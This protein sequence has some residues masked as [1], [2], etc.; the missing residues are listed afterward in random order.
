[1]AVYAEVVRKSPPSKITGSLPYNVVVSGYVRR[2]DTKQPLANARVDINFNGRTATVYT[3]SSGYFS[4]TFTVYEYGA[5]FVDIKATPKESDVK[6]SGLYFTFSIWDPQPLPAGNYYWVA[7]RMLV[8]GK[9][10]EDYAPVYPGDEVVVEGYLYK[11]GSPVPGAWI[12]MGFIYGTMPYVHAKTNSKGYFKFVT[13]APD[14]RAHYDCGVRMRYCHLFTEPDVTG[15]PAA[16][17]EF[18]ITAACPELPN[19]KFQDAWFEVAGK[20]YNAGSTIEIDPGTTVTAKA[21]IVNNGGAGTVYFYVYDAK[22]GKYV[23]YVSKSM[24]KGETWTPSI[25]LKQSGD[26]DY[27]LHVAYKSTDG[28]IYVTDKAGCKE[29]VIRYLVEKF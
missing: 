18:F 23:D 22:A 12:S 3:D 4:K 15:Y 24:Q 11:D 19:P 2:S 13:T 7:L 16:V 8:N 10:V 17:W 5:Y 26:A 1:M 29:N 6:R 28:K 27:E 20:R 14:W 9:E 25:T 21:T